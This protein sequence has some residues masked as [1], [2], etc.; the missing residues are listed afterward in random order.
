MRTRALL[1]SILLGIL[2][3]LAACGGSSSNGPNSAVKVTAVPQ[4]SRVAIVVL[5]N[6]SY[7]DVIGNASMPYLNSLASQYS[8]LASYYA[9][10][11][12]SIPNYFILTAGNPETFDDAFSGTVTDD[13]LAREFIA[14]GVSWKAYEESIPGAGYTGGDSGLYIERHNPF[15][16][17]SDVRND[18]AQAAN[19]VPFSQLAVDMSGGSLPNFMWI[20]PNAIDSAHDCPSSDPSCSLSSRLTTA[21][22]WLKTNIQPLLSNPSFS[23]NGLLIVVF[24]EGEDTDV[25]HVGGHVACVFA[26][27]HVKTHYSSNATYQHQDTLSLIGHALRLQH[28]PGL[29]ASGGSMLEFFQ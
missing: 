27:T 2:L 5:E 21:D 9:N 13:N 19:I 16:Y 1:T 6:A 15:S 28:T 26:G 4:F 24:D 18:P 17:F 14:S 20:G 12:P 7:H 10:A 23:A 29:G 3:I 25:D 22:N 11:H 8:S